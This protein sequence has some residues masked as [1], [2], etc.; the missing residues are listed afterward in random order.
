MF[1]INSPGYGF[2]VLGFISV[3]MYA[4][5]SSAYPEYQGQAFDAFEIT[6]A[7]TQCH[8]SIESSDSTT[9]QTEQSTNIEQ[10][11]EEVEPT[12]NTD[13]ESITVQSCDAESN[14]KSCR[15]LAEFDLDE[16]G[17]LELTEVKAAQEAFFN[18]ADTDQSADL[19]VE[20]LQAAQKAE[21]QTQL[22]QRFYELDTDDDNLLS[23]TELQPGIMGKFGRMG[24]FIFWLDSDGDGTITLEEFQAHPIEGA[25]SCREAKFSRLDND[26]DGVITQAEFI[27][28]VPLFDRFDADEDGIITLEEL[29][30]P[31][32]RGQPH[33][34]GHFKGGH[35]GGKHF[36]H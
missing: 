9:T 31:L 35:F 11:T 1:K 20:E 6:E 18:A 24:H 21:R 16:N 10:I 7:C 25:N 3:F 27:D 19:T 12:I 2:S 5:L 28:N 17:Q 14:R 26:G 4:P 22:A 13:S 32:S 36:R 23:E 34:R 33:K 30:Q 8:R 29:E 15:L